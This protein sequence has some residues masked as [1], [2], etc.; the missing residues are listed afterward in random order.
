MN[1]STP[2]SVKRFLRGSRAMRKA[3][4]LTALL[5]IGAS[6]TQAAENAAQ[7]KTDWPVLI[8]QLRQ[9]LDRMPGHAAT[10]QQLAVAY[11]NYA[12]TL[13][14]QRRFP[15]AAQAL[16][17]SI[18]LE[19]S[20]PQFRGNLALIHVQE[21]Q[22]LYQGNR[23]KDAKQ[24]LQQAL[25][26]N[27]KEASAYELLG[28]IEYN[29]EHLKQ[30]KAA[31]EQALAINPNLL[32]VTEKLDRLKQ[33][34]PVESQFEKVSQFYFDIRYA[35]DLQSQTGFDIRDVLLEARRTVGTDFQYWPKHQLVVLVYSAEEFRR[36][37]QDTPDWL[38]GQYDGKIRVPLPGRGLDQQAVRRTLVHEYT[39]AVV[40]DLTHDRC[41]IWLNEGLAEYQAW[42]GQTPTWPTLRLALAHNRLVPWT[43]LADQFSTALPVETV[44]LAYEQSHS[45]VRYLVEHS[46]FW[47]IRR[48]LKAMDNQTS[49]DEAFLAEFHLSLSRLETQWRKWLMETLG[50]PPS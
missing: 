13:A 43:S 32:K 16:A 42:K 3:P 44:A 48:V 18:R 34:L 33:E 28:E 37:R 24:V 17:E 50:K 11:N 27:P 49:L 21:A 4:L 10:R 25:A 38:A 19:P 26:V 1:P 31:W 30:A 14:N 8:S 23:G 36:I 29:S 15:E 2:V 39:H 7:D 12:V 47:R 46:G 9:Q 6:V 35:S 45:I 5:L 22:L 20:D 40:H 41:P